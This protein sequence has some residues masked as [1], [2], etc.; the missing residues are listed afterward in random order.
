MGVGELMY[1]EWC[2]PSQM[3]AVECMA[4]GENLGGNGKLKKEKKKIT[5]ARLCT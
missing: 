1:A 4:G 3:V 5:Y 2:F